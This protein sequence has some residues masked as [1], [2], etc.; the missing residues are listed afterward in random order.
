MAQTL[1]KLFRI[2]REAKATKEKE[3]DAER[4]GKKDEEDEQVRGEKKIKEKD[5]DVKMRRG[6]KW[7]D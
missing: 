1:N 3:Y 5:D 7:F 4:E 2:T 6:K